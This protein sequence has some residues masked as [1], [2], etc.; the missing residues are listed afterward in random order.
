MFLLEMQPEAAIAERG[1]VADTPLHAHDRSRPRRGPCAQD[2]DLARA[3]VHL[4]VRDGYQWPAER[5]RYAAFDDDHAAIVA[6]WML[7]VPHD[8]A[9]GEGAPA[10]D[11]S[12]QEEHDH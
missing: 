9:R 8:A 10:S 11:T 12:G 1:H 5:L 3:V 4:V 2:R 6:S 7:L